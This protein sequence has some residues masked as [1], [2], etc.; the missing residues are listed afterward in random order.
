MQSRAFDGLRRKKLMETSAEDFLAILNGGK[1]SVAHYLKRLHNLVVNLG[2][3]A[4]PVLVPALWPSPSPRQRS[5]PLGLCF[6]SRWLLRSAPFPASG[7]ESDC[8][9]PRPS[10]LLETQS[11]GDYHAGNERR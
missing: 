5:R 8:F 11:H 6:R 9:S 3:L 7:K 1:V 2:W 4:H 10:N